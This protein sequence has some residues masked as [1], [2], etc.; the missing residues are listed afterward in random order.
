MLKYNYIYMSYMFFKGA[1]N[2]IPKIYGQ[3]ELLGC[4]IMFDENLK[5][6][7]IEMN[8]NPALFFDTT[9]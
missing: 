9:T 4:D 1:K 7:L 6:F 2:S 8:T 5:P 3:F